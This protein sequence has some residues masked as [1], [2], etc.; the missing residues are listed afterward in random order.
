ML[1]PYFIGID[2]SWHM[3]KVLQ[4]LNGQLSL[5]YG[6]N[7]PLNESTM[8]EAEWGANRPVIPYSPWFHMFAVLFTYVP[9]PLVL[10]ANLFHTLIDCSRAL[11]IGLLGRKLGLS[12]RQSLFASLLY[13]VTPVTFLLL[14]W[15]NV[16]T[17]F[18]MWWTLVSTSVY[19]GGLQ[20]ARPARAVY[21]AHAA[22]AGDAADLHGDGGVYAAVPGATGRCA[23]AD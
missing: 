6:T 21:R 23:L 17:A 12:E 22:A 5:F 1:Y 9:L 10:T 16:P 2:V 15:G 19:R 20:A 4:I 3:N 13:A 7:S 11:L 14:S 18:G 8:P